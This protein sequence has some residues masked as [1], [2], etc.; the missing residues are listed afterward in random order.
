LSEF[1]IFRG[2]INM[3]NH[4][5][6]HAQDSATQIGSVNG[7]VYI[8]SD[9][10]V[11]YRAP[12]QAPPLP[13]HFV[14]R[15]EVTGPLQA[16]LVENAPTRPGVLVVSA[17]HGLGGIGKSTL[18]AALAWNPE[19]QERFPDGILWV[20]L[21][22]QPEILSLL[23]SL[24]QAMRDSDFRPTTPEAASTH[25]RTL[26]RDKALLLVVDDVWNPNHA[27]PFK[28]GGPRCQVVITTRR[29]DV[30]DEVG[31]ELHE[32]DVMTPDQALTLLSARLQRPLETAER[33]E[34]LA[35]ARALGYLP[36]ALE[37]TAVRVMR[38]MSW[39][40]LRQA[41]DQEIA[42]LETLD[43]SP[44]R[45]RRRETRLEACFNLSLN[46]LRDEDEEAWRA[47]VA[48]GVLPED[49]LIAAPMA[50]TLWEMT[51][52]QARDL[53]DLLWNDALLL[54]GVRVNAGQRTWPAYRLHDLWHDMARKLLIAPPPKGLGL[55]LLKAH[56]AL[57]RR[58]H[59]R[60]RQGLWHTLPDDGYIHRHLLWHLERARQTDQ[61]HALFQEETQEGR[62]GW[63]RAC[64]QLDQTA[65]FLDDVNLA[66]S[67][68]EQARQIGLQCRYGL[69]LASFNSLA[70][71]LPAGLLTALV[72]HGLW[73]PAQGLA[74][75]RQVP[76]Q[77]NRAEAL[78][79]LAPRLPENLRKT[80]L[81][82]A[83]AA[84]Q[85]IQ[86]EDNRA[87]ALSALAPRLPE[88]LRKTALQD[89]LAAAQ[90]IQKEDDRAEALRALAPHLPD[91][92]LP[93][94]LAAA[95]GIQRSPRPRGFRMSICGHGR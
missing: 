28:I 23:S 3:T 1:R 2:S 31:A 34:A 91:A 22:Q 39:S 35:L 14:P 50:A 81:Q 32:M 59:K 12:F 72:S 73:S 67:A 55:P 40:R 26:V 63:F 86:K 60:T 21:G 94:A 49:V 88:N 68:A 25:L 85:G 16:R 36:L 84:A 44:R 51:P 6:Q 43:S 83:L 56:A 48:L 75:A 64:E 38:G 90:G 11:N 37:L 54:P 7:P 58:Y 24:I 79:A 62:N 95:Q 45:R 9:R 77:R 5:N 78:A 33:E 30:A 80:A 8:Q 19:I 89:A 52:D 82:D 69:I 93:D 92:L 4:I 70:N 53:L 17:I 13:Q 18:A 74:Y 41:L 29:A 10:P 20:T 57:L 76:G 42:A 66:W 27:R 15:P 65:G 71:N 87:E 61:I 47:F 46:A